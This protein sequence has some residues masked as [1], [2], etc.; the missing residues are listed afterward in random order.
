M[1]PSHKVSITSPSEESDPSGIHEKGYF[2]KDDDW[3]HCSN[4]DR[5]YKILQ[6]HTDENLGC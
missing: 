6:L 5:N 2:A 4:K 3:R 1:R